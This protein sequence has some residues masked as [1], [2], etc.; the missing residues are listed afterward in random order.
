MNFISEHP[1]RTQIRKNCRYPLLHAASFW[2][3]IS[4]I[5]QLQDGYYQIIS[6]LQKVFVNIIAVMKSLFALVLLFGARLVAATPHPVVTANPLLKRD[7]SWSLPASSK[8]FIKW[9]F[10][11]KTNDFSVC[12]QSYVTTAISKMEHP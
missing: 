5:F 10:L 7:T 12:E 9:S 2:K 3:Y 11:Q 6:D 8:L 1:L 4:E